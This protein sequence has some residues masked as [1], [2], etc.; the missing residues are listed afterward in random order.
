MTQLNEDSFDSPSIVEEQ[1][2]PETV[3]HIKVRFSVFFDGT[4]NSRNNIDTRLAYENASLLSKL[5][6]EKHKIYRKC[7]NE[8]SYKADYTNV[9]TM[10][11]YVEANRELAEKVNGYDLTLKTYIDGSGTD[12]DEKDSTLGYGLGWGPTGVRAKVKKGMDKVVD[13]TIRE[14]ADPTTVID[15]LTIDTF[16]FSRG[17]A[18]ARNFIY[19]VLFGDKLASLKEQF[20]TRGYI[21]LNVEV[22]FAGL[23]D[24]VSS[25]GVTYNNDVSQ[26]KLDSVVHAK[27]VI[28]LTAA[29]EHRRN[30]SLT[31]IKSAQ[32][33]G[34]G[35]EYFL[36][37]VHS[38]VGGSYTTQGDGNENHVVFDGE[39]EEAIADQKG[40]IAAGWYKKT[41]IRFIDLGYY[42]DDEMFTMA[43]LE[44]TRNNI[45]NKYCRISLNIMA[46]FV[47]KNKIMLIEEFD[48]RNKVP[49]NL[50]TIKDKL[51][52]YVKN[53]S[54]QNSIASHWQHNEPWL[55]DLRHKHLHFS[56]KVQLGLA[57]RFKN[58]R[59][60][61]KVYEG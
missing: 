13:K 54:G 43:I 33:A 40:L 37:G 5:D 28:H 20:T 2:V 23:Y 42:S 26:L 50:T 7:K 10:E 59:R 25:H 47:R 39:K 45:D 16:G 30:F 12:D 15:R 46:D 18:G 1:E 29:E 61:R 53:S 51:V 11:R 27:K 55:K 48:D 22:D 56:S 4:L 52:N 60:Y 9:A 49:A 8:D 31:S 6:F 41:E 38:D 34:V 3:E 32:N 57:P 44:V 14:M 21:V 17:A 24:T 19:E 36:P 35:E 58:G